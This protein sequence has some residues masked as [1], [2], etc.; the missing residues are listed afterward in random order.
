MRSSLLLLILASPLFAQPTL[1]DTS[2]TAISRNG[3]QIT[4]HGTGLKEP[5]SIWSIPAAQAIF[6]NTS[7][8]S[9]LCNITFSQPIDDQIVA[10]RVATSSGISNPILIAIDDLSTT[11][12]NRKNK[13]IAEAQ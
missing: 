9:A 8:D 11:L 6:S 3:G 5:L 7:T 4:L 10:L 1:D 12:A 2:P 13:S